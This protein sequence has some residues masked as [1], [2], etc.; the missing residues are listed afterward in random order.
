MDYSKDQH[1]AFDL[2]RLACSTPAPI[3]LPLA[4]SDPGASVL[5]KPYSGRSKSF[6]EDGHRWMIRAVELPKLAKILEVDTL[7]A[8]L[9]ALVGSML[10]G[11]IF[12]DVTYI[13]S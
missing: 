7:P 10:L 6:G 9:R 13:L 2:R 5:A 3:N 4:H 12:N 11:T 8:R 1:I